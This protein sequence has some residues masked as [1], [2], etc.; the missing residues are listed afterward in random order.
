MKLRLALLL[1]MTGLLLGCASVPTVRVLQ[2]C[3]KPPP[4]DLGLPPGAMDHSF[5]ATMQLLLRGKLPEQTNYELPSGSV[6]L[7]TIR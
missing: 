5:G 3:P 7:L 2:V 1:T 4:L 6:R